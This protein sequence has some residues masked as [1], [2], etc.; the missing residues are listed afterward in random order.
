MS[1]DLFFLFFVFL[2]CAIIFYNKIFKKSNIEK[3]FHIYLKFKKEEKLRIKNKIEENK[4]IIKAEEERTKNKIAQDLKIK[5]FRSYFIGKTFVLFWAN[6]F[7]YKCVWGCSKHEMV[8]QIFDIMIKFKKKEIINAL[9]L[10]LNREV[11]Q[12]YLLVLFCESLILRGYHIRGYYILHYCTVLEGIIL[13]RIISSK[14]SNKDRDI[15]NYLRI[16]ILEIIESKNLSFD[17]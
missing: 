4:R 8:L 5:K 9:D 10:G 16:S 12:L 6:E 14:F 2:L 3:R 13:T 7:P 1:I 15:F 11:I 17:N